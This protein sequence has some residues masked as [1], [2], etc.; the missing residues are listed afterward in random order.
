M[1][2]LAFCHGAGNRKTS[3]SGIRVVPQRDTFVG[4]VAALQENAGVEQ[5]GCR[6]EV[7]DGEQ[8][9]TESHGAPSDLDAGHFEASVSG[10]VLGLSLRHQHLKCIRYRLGS[11]FGY[12]LAT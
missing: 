4:I 6:V 9:I 1:H 7:A 2:G 3:E 10:V 12:R 11:Q 5:N 8:C